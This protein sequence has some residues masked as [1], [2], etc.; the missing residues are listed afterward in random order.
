VGLPVICIYPA[1]VFHSIV[2]AVKSVLRT[3]F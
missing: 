3:D 2:E 1:E